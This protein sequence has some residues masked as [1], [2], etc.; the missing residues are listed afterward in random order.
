MKKLGTFLALSLLTS[1]AFSG[2]ILPDLSRT[3]SEPNSSPVAVAFSK[4]DSA[5]LVLSKNWGTAEASGSDLYDQ[6]TK[7]LNASVF[8]SKTSLHMEFTTTLAN[9]EIESLR[10]N[11]GVST[12]I[13]DA[14]ASFGMSL[15]DNFVAGLSAS[16][17]HI[18]ELDGSTKETNDVYEITPGVGFKIQPNMAVGAGIHQRFNKARYTTVGTSSNEL[19]ALATSEIFVGAAY[20]VDQKIGENGFGVEAVVSH[21]P[22]AKETSQGQS[23]S[24]GSDTTF[25]VDGNYTLDQL[26]VGATVMY[27][28]GDNYDDTASRKAQFYTVRPE[29]LVTSTIYVAPQAT[30]AN[31]KNTSDSGADGSDTTK[32]WLYGTGVGMRTAL[33]DL[34]LT[35][36]HGS[37]DVSTGNASLDSNQVTAR[38]SFYF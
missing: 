13:Y 33:Y 26:D 35:Y 19:P 21:T 27:S 14:S 32:G 5:S 36:V 37:V 12:N 24:Q 3:K 31:L 4:R 20:G 8:T 9:D 34:E 25:T 29:Y 23:V 2:E 22:K 28:T 6:D 15:T 17:N 16:I 30:Y 7:S 1:Q 10:T 11:S 38:A 18:A